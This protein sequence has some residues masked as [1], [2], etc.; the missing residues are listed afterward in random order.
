MC[1]DSDWTNYK[2][3]CFKISD[4]E[5]TWLDAQ[6][7]CNEHDSNLLIVNDTNIA[8]KNLVSNIRMNIN[9]LFKEPYLFFFNL[10]FISKQKS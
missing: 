3:F 8:L 2:E 4:N 9:I 1:G 6:A 5:M 7:K 10:F